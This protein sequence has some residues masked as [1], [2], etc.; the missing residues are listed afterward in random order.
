MKRHII[1]YLVSTLIFLWVSTGYMLAWA[2]LIPLEDRHITWSEDRWESVFWR[3]FILEW[4]GKAFD[5]SV[6]RGANH[7]ADPE[8]VRWISEAIPRV[9]R[10]TNSDSMELGGWL[11]TETQFTCAVIVKNDSTYKGVSYDSFG[12]AGLNAI[13]NHNAKNCRLYSHTYHNLHAYERCWIEVILNIK[14]SKKYWCAVN[15]RKAIL[16]LSMTLGGR[17]PPYN[18]G[19][20]EGPRWKPYTRKKGARVVLSKAFPKFKEEYPKFKKSYRVA[21]E[22]EF[23]QSDRI[24]G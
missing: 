15:C 20:Q 23:Y 8:C 18:N 21:R 9:R 17:L 16:P 22:K 10:A 12:A 24:G 19:I 7:H 13:N 1:R 14:K 6:I 5:G 4:R 2:P 3:H 11:W